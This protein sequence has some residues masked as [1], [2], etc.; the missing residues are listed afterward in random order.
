MGAPWA[1]VEPLVQ[2]TGAPTGLTSAQAEAMGQPQVVAYMGPT[3]NRS[4][5]ASPET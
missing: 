4:G 5:L 1:K 3:A 2:E